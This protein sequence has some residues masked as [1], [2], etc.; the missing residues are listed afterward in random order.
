MKYYAGHPSLRGVL[1]EVLRVNGEKEIPYDPEE[2]LDKDFDSEG[3]CDCQRTSEVCIW[4]QIT[5]P[6]G[7]FGYRDTSYQG[8]ED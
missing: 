6:K 3:Q 7:R 4:C 2:I 5:L 8:A 1:A